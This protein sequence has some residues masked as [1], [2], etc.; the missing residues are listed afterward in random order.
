VESE[1]NPIGKVG[2]CKDLQEAA[3]ICRTA[4]TRQPIWNLVYIIF[5]LLELA[6]LFRLVDYSKISTCSSVPSDRK[7]IQGIID[8]EQD[9]RQMKNLF[10]Y[11]TDMLLLW[12]KPCADGF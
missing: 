11:F 5:L 8:E 1:W 7:L 4:A 2:E 10:F 3:L 6:I 12:A 9:L